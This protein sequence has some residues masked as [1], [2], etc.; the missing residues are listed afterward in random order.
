[1]V[2]MVLLISDELFHVHPSHVH[3]DTAQTWHR[4]PFQSLKTIT[5]EEEKN[6]DQH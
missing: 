5:E 1:V 4:S 3:K 6:N 2:I